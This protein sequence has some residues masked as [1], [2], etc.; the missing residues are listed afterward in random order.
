MAAAPPGVHETAKAR[1]L[2]LAALIRARTRRAQTCRNGIFEGLRMLENS[3]NLAH[4]SDLA[5]IAKFY[6]DWAQAWPA[7][8]IAPQNIPYGW[9]KGHWIFPKFGSIIPVILKNIFDFFE[10]FHLDRK[11]AILNLVWPFSFHEHV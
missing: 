6:S 9:D 11:S 10:I 2:L 8:S 4:T 7:D 3:P 1:S 5:K